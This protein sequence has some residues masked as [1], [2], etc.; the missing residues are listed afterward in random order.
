MVSKDLDKDIRDIG[1]RYF[2][3][4]IG[5]ECELRGCESIPTSSMC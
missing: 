4:Q 5:Y 1:G 2:D 3:T